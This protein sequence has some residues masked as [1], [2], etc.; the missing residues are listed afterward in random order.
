[1]KLSQYHNNIDDIF[2]PN[3]QTVYR[4]DTIS[5]ANILQK[6]WKHLCLLKNYDLIF[7]PFWQEDESRT[8]NVGGKGLGLSIVNN[9]VSKYGWKITVG[10][11]DLGGAKFIISF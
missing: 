5:Y 6:S 8:R 11:S 3:L 4:L 10:K 9:I 1:M 7:T 2:V